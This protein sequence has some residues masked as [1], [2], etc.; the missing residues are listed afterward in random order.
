MM[1]KR[2][3][4]NRNK[5]SIP[6]C[7]LL[8]LHPVAPAPRT[9]NVPKRKLKQQLPPIKKRKK[10][11]KKKGRI[12]KGKEERGGRK[13]PKE[14][15]GSGWDTEV[16]TSDS[17]NNADPTFANPT[18][19]NPTDTPP[20]L[21]RQDSMPSRFFLYIHTH[22]HT[23]F[24]SHFEQYSN[25]CGWESKQCLR[26]LPLYLQGNAGSW[27]A[28]LNTSFESYDALIN[29]LKEQFSNPASLWLLRQQLSSRKQNETESLANYAAENRR[30]CKRLGLSDNVGMHYFIQGLHP[31]LKGHVILEQ[32]K[33]EAENLAHLKEAVS[34]STPKLADPNHKIWVLKYFIRFLMT[35]R[36]L[37]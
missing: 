20:P 22:T 14:C 15:E 24:L 30:L 37:L 4:W 18:S 9:T 5:S 26:A 1:A 8:L 35:Q 25:F 33:T 27:Y 17:K 12:C 21:V 23:A 29:A 7:S 28:S 11:R 34:V 13:S 2:S 10:K 19:A 32:P 3:H 16:W 31:D 36:R 6:F